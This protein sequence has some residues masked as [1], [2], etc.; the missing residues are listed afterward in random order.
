MKQ[1]DNDPW[2]FRPGLVDWEVLADQVWPW[3]PE[4]A[5]EPTPPGPLTPDED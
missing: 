2:A 1:P 5:P 4:E 3:E